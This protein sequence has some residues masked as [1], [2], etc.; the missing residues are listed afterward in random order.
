MVGYLGPTKRRKFQDRT[1]WD[2]HGTTD[3]L[4]V[5]L[6]SVLHQVKA[7]NSK[8]FNHPH[9]NFQLVAEPWDLQPVYS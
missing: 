7:K 9:P 1:G 2:P 6:I 4:R 8:V 3:G 5:D